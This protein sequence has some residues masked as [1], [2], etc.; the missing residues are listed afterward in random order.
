MADVLTSPEI[1]QAALDPVPS[2]FSSEHVLPTPAF[3]GTRALV[4]G[5]A[6]RY[7]RSHGAKS[8]E[9]RQV[10]L[11]AEVRAVGDRDD[12]DLQIHRPNPWSKSADT[13]NPEERI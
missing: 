11:V 12:R 5:G 8:Q 9:G 7:R 1:F 13:P 4:T 6:P 3:T 2:A 10:P